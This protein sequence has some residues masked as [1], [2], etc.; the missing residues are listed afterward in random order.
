MLIEW[1]KRVVILLKIA[2]MN[3]NILLTV[4]IC[5]LGLGQSLK[6]VVQKCVKK[7]IVCLDI[8]RSQIGFLLNH[9]AVVEV[10][11]V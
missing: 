8:N 10:W 11:I 5:L 7:K 1:I 4:L 3:M 9:K 6:I 2:N